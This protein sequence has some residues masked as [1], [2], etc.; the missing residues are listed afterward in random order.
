MT[1]SD[2]ID[3]ELDNARRTFPVG[4]H[5]SGKVTLI[6]KPGTIGLFADL[7]REP[8]GFVDV[9]HLPM[10][11][12]EWP[13]VGTVTEFEVLTHTRGQVRLWPLDDAYRSSTARLPM[14]EPEWHTVKHRHPVGSEVNA[15]ITHVVPLNRE[16]WVMFDGVW[17]SRPWTGTPP[18][19]GTTA[20][21]VIDRHL[22]TTRRVLLCGCN[23]GS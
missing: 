22:D 3:Q 5:I 1:E 2:S 18:T 12:Q 8:G 9:L 23:P 11:T 17:A 10:S 20:R 15:E 19:V 13:P 14:S 16:Y 21:F 7:G 4:E 6:P